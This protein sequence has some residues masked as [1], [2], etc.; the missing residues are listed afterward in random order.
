MNVIINERGY[1]ESGRNNSHIYDTSVCAG[2]FSF[3]KDQQIHS[4]LDLGCGTGE[5]CAYF[6]TQNIECDAYDGNPNTPE[7]S[8]GIGK[9]LDLSIDFDLNKKYDC[10]LSLEVGEHIPEKYEAIFINNIC[11]H[12]SKWIILS[13]AIPGQIGDG[14]VNCQTN[15]Y[16]INQ[17][18]TYNFSYH[19]EISDY[20]RM[21][22][23]MPW[24]RNTIMV[25][26]YQ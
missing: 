2:I 8:N 18:K 6:L 10:V 17:L 5:Y 19:K 26:L 20:L 1:W 11:K 25:F 14:H 24:F 9:V 3:L 15:E 13:W 4:I 22:S 21:N 16:I 12:S 23:I 7:L